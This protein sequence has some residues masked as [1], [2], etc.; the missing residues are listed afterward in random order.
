LLPPT[1]WNQVFAEEG[2]S[3]P[4]AGPASDKDFKMPSLAPGQ[5]GGMIVGMS[6]API[7]DARVTV[8]HPDSGTTLSA[9]TDDVG[10]WVVSNVPSGRIKITTSANGFHSYV[11]EANYDASRALPLSVS[12]NVGSVSETVAVTSS[13]SD[14]QTSSA[15]IDK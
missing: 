15:Q 2:S 8:L 6:G 4:Y 14:L 7:P 3:F 5:I 13:L 9:T 1:S 12:L 10:R 11:Q